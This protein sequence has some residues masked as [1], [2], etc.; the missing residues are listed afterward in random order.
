MACKIGI[1]KQDCYP[2]WNFYYF[3]EVT[4][5]EKFEDFCDKYWKSK[6]CANCRCHLDTAYIYIVETL[7]EK[8]LLPDD[9][10]MLCCKCWSEKY[11]THNQKS[12]IYAMK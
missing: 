7:R 3:K 5:E 4:D 8:G 1:C 6:R 9:Y 2:F 11:G 10:E 12:F